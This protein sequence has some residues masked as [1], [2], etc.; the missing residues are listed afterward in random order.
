METQKSVISRFLNLLHDKAFEQ[1][2]KLFANAFIRNRKL[3]F[4]RV[5]GMLLRMVK[6]SLQVD[7]NWLG[8]LLDLEPASKQAFSKARHKLSP[9]CFRELFEEAL[10][11]HYTLIGNEGCWKGYR[12]IACDGST[13]R[14][15]ESEELAE[16]FGSCASSN[17]AWVFS[18]KLPFCSWGGQ[19]EFLQ[20]SSVPCNLVFSFVALR[21]FYKNSA[22]LVHSD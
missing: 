16:E 20:R 13:L 18:H 17:V 3:S 8:D 14:L 2:H 22:K 21:S 15:P 7:C 10:K 4:T 6:R 19:S 12:L 9:E 1:R 5:A 11:V